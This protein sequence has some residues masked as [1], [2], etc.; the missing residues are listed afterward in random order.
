MRSV[1]PGFGRYHGAPM[2]GDRFQLT[3]K[4]R[5]SLGSAETRRLR[6]N[7]FIP[8]VLY[9]KGEPRAIARSTATCRRRPYATKPIPSSP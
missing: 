4:E 3:V 5:D 9:G 7:G 2:S 6:R 8:G 1:V